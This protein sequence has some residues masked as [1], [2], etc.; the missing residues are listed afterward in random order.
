MHLYLLV[1][2]MDSVCGS[3]G[4]YIYVCMYIYRDIEI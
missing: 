1:P 3:H 2:L 4:Q